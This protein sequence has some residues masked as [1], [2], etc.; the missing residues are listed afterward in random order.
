MMCLHCSTPLMRTPM[1]TLGPMPNTFPG[2][3]SRTLFPF[4]PNNATLE[5]KLEIQVLSCP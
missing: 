4:W 3:G 2:P 5:A 1:Q